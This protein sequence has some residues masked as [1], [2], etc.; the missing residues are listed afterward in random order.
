[1]LLNIVTYNIR[2]GLGIDGRVDLNRVLDVLKTSKADVISLN[3]VDSRRLRSGFK[4]QAK[5]LATN[6]E[7][8]YVFVPAHRRIIAQTGN[9]VLSKFPIAESELIPLTSTRQRRVALRAVVAAGNNTATIDITCICTHFGLSSEER[10]AQ[11]E[12]VIAALQA[13][14]KEANPIVLMGDLN[15]S[16]DN[17]EVRTISQQLIDVVKDKDQPTFPN[18]HPKARIDY[19]FISKNCAIIDAGVIKSEA[20]D[21][22]AV[23]AALEV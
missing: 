14:C 8:H 2:H 7:M 22:L 9:A 11:A 19:I 21:H 6:L 15:A 4:N 16:P 12:E 23:F 17:P 5:W 3:E 13:A 10:R 20:S 18:P 1:M